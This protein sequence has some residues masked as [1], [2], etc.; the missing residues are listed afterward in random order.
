[1]HWKGYGE[2]DNTWE[3]ETDV[4]QYAQGSAALLKFQR[5]QKA[6]AALKEK[7]PSQKKRLGKIT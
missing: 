2:A 3:K 4:V 1:M 6:G 7:Q 5:E